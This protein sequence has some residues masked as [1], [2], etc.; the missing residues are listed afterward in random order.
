MSPRGE[1][2]ETERE[3]EREVEERAPTESVR[4]SRRERRRREEEE[5]EEEE[6]SGP[7]KDLDSQQPNVEA[8]HL[9]LKTAARS[10]ASGSSWGWKSKRWDEE[11]GEGGGGGGGE[12][13]YKKGRYYVSILGTERA[14]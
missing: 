7:R 13:M 6:R 4:R 11:G 14:F 5:E 2:G 10:M 9:Q 8:A 1:R 12:K 3:R